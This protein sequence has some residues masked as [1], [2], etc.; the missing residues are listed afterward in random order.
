MDWKSREEFQRSRV[1][2]RA[3]GKEWKSSWSCKNEI[4][5]RVAAEE[6]E[7]ECPGV[8]VAMKELGEVVEGFGVQLGLA[9]ESQS[10]ACHIVEEEGGIETNLGY[11]ENLQEQICM[12]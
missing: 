12:I 8:G 9:A 3:A 10:F 5:D 7:L 2:V 1:R 11:L 6:S 4:E